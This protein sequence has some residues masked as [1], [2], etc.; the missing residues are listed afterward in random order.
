[1]FDEETRAAS[2]T[3]LKEFGDAFAGRGA[4]I[5]QAIGAF[6]PL[7]E[8]IIPVARNLVEPGHEP[9]AVHRRARRRGAH[10]RAGRREPGAAVR[11]TST[12]PSA[13]CARSPA[14]TSRSRSPRGP[15]TLDAAIEAFPRPA[16]VPGQHRGRCSASCSP[17]PPRSRPRRRASPARSRSARRR[18]AATRRST[19][20]SPRC[21][22]RSPTFAEDPLVPRGIRRLTETAQTLQADAQV[23]RAGADSPATTSRSGSATSPR[24][25]P[26][27]T[28]TAP[29]SG[30]S[31]SPRRRARTTRAGS[32]RRRPTARRC[33][34]TCTRNPYPNT[35]SPGQP[36]GVRGGQRALH[37]RPDRD[38][39]RARD[40][41]G[42]D[43]AE[44]RRVSRPRRRQPPQPVRR[45]PRRARGDRRPHATSASRSRSRSR[46]ATRSRR[47]SSR[48]TACG[49]TRRCGSPASTSARSRRSTPRRA[50]TTRVVTMEISDEGRP[51]A[52][53]RHGEDP[54]AHLP[55]GQLLRRPAARHAGRARSS[56]TAGCSRS[57]RRRRR[58]SSTRCSP[59]CSPTRGRT[60]RTCSTRSARRSA[61]KPSAED[62]APGRSVRARRDRGGVVQRRLRRHRA[63]REGRRRRSTRRFLGTEPEQDL[64]R[65]IDGA[66][67]HRRGPRAQRGPAPGPRHQ[68]QRRR[69][70]RSR[71]RAATCRPRS[72]SCRP[73][74][75]AAN[76]RLRRRSTPRSRPRA[77]SRARSSRASARRRRRSTPRSRGSRRRA[78]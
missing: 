32:P 11:R 8:D 20:G 46:A 73:T 26:R 10:R 48:P 67:P 31:S 33:R 49:P 78:R 24:C 54:A 6:R 27:A 36:Q 1:M 3:N 30:S 12:P 76:A 38:R 53:G 41:A 74:L 13:R 4:S 59:R 44:G 28:T 37:R 9:P 42:R 68:L 69:W 52:H 47:R 58:S 45:R 77:R 56:T 2:Q 50:R 25:C 7:L 21:S 16:A 23:P 66:R 75:E 55:R 61:A 60:C 65:L 64:S 62:D 57:R 40:P 18:C 70:P 14:R 17:A 22:T 15:A 72:A 51:V 29:G 5:N 35:A 34:T 71:R 39:Q 43:G 63:G 19:S